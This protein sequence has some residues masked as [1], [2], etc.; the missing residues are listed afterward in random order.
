METVFCCTFRNT[1][2][3]MVQRHTENHRFDKTVGEHLTFTKHVL[4]STIWC[5][6]KYMTRVQ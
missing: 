5:V 2:R 3:Y 1:N 4:Y 6:S